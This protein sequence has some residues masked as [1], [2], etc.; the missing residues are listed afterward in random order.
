M[1]KERL[2][3]E[4]I[5]SL[6]ARLP[7]SPCLRADAVPMF[8]LIVPLLVNCLHLDV[9]STASDD[10]GCGGGG[11]DQERTER[12]VG[13]TTAAFDDRVGKDVCMFWQGGSEPLSAVWLCTA[14][15]VRTRRCQT[16]PTRKAPSCDK[17][18][19]T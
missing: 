13:R 2:A 19:A 1:V 3:C 9:T 4:N 7:G 11:E 18:K 6:G 5:L 16:S 15:A 14:K 17:R 12:D 8:S 10:R